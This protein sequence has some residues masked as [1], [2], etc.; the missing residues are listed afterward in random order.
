MVMNSKSR[1][2]ILSVSCDTLTVVVDRPTVSQHVCDTPLSY[3]DEQ[4]VEGGVSRQSIAT[5]T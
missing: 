3:E 4:N 2:K 1:V 5:T